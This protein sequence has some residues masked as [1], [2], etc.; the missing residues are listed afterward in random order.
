MT[1]L[2]KGKIGYGDI[3][4]PI[5]HAAN[6]QEKLVFGWPHGG[7]AWAATAASIIAPL[8]ALPVEVE[9]KYNVLFHFEHV[10][11]LDDG[12]MHN[13]G[14][15]KEAFDRKRD[16]GIVR[17]TPLRNKEPLHPSKHW[18]TPDV[19]W[20]SIPG[21]DIDY[22]TPVP[23]A[24]DIL[25]SAEFCIGY[26]GSASWLARWCGCPQAVLSNSSITRRSFSQAV[27]LKELPADLDDAR[28]LAKENLEATRKKWTADF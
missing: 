20:N 11:Y 14:F 2:W 17:V 23:E 12:P 25:L 4:S 16:G 21:K 19:D 27:V 22:R 7:S 26:H 10:N 8:H 15:H 5:C 1:I 13:V 3:I 6:R 28:E 9:H 24:I 18:K